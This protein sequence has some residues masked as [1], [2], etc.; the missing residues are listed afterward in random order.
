M[1]SPLKIKILQES[2]FNLTEKITSR[3]K[4]VLRHE[5]EPEIIDIEKSAAPNIHSLSDDSNNTV[6]LLVTR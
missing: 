6:I 3:V 5:K 1:W 4:T 2:F